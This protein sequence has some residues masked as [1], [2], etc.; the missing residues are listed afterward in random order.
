LRLLTRLDTDRFSAHAD[1][2]SAVNIREAGLA[3]LALLV[4][5]G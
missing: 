4:V 2:V 5:F 1:F 3:S